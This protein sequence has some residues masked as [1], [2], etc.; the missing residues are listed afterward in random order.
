MAAP[1][2]DCSLSCAPGVAPG[3]RS[4]GLAMR[5]RGDG[6][7]PGCPWRG[8]APEGA[9]SRL[10]RATPPDATINRCGAAVHAAARPDRPP[11]RSWLTSEPPRADS[12]RVSTGLDERERRE[13]RRKTEAAT[14][15]AIRA[16]G[17][18]GRRM[19]I[20]DRALADGGFTPRELAAPAPESAGDK[21][22]RLVDH[23]LAWALTNLRRDG[24]VENP[25]RSVWCLAAAARETPL[26][27]SDEPVFVD[28]LD[29]LRRMSYREYLRS[30]E[31]RGTRA[32]ALERAGHCC[33]LDVTHTDGLEVHHRTYERLGCELATDVVV[34][35]H[36]CHALHHK[37]FGR[38]GRRPT[39]TAAAAA[40]SPRASASPAR[41]PQP[42][43]LLRRLFSS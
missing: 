6:V 34:L 13:L 15:D 4:S 35:C 24:L 17:G 31:W 23:Q 41:R 20:R 29:E 43:S 3:G 39:V 42:R 33:S 37:Q 14:L 11:A 7:S 8:T 10:G 38:P 40:L 32:A 36:A 18:E 21:F 1:R 26:P 25:S 5:W 22:E 16:L 2:T 19:A 9:G 28:R 27:A 30:P 12:A